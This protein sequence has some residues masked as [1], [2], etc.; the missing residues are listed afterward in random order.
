[1][2]FKEIKDK[3][4]YFEEHYLFEEVP[5]LTDQKYCIHCC[6][7]IIVGNY[8]VEIDDEG[9]EFIVCPN[10]PICNGNILDWMSPR[11]SNN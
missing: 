9:E 1:M 2:K 3:Q 11:N 6:T 4:S 8:K 7:N 10:A 5:K